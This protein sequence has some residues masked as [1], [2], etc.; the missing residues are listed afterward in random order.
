M[1]FR[2][3]PLN[4]RL[5]RQRVLLHPR[6]RAR[7][8]GGARS[9]LVAAALGVAF[10]ALFGCYLV[11]RLTQWTLDR[12]LYDNPDFAVRDI[13]VYTD[14]VIA[15]EQVRRWAGVQP[16][17]NLL[18]L[19]LAEVKRHLEFIPHIASAS[20]ERVLP[21]TLR[22]RVT[23]RVPVARVHLPRFRPGGGVEPVVYQLDADG[24]V[25]APLAACQRATP[26]FEPEKPL[27]VIT[28]ANPHWFAAGR[29]AEAPPV[30]AAL[31]LVAAFERSPLAGRVELRRI[32]VGAPQ[33]L[34][35]T[36]A[37]GTEVTF[38]GSDYERQLL[39]WAAIQEAGARR[40]RVPASLD[41]AVSNNIP[42]CWFE[43]GASLL[44]PAA[45]GKPSA[46][47]Q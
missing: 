13:V 4:R 33:V 9:R 44:P 45:A 26:P 16:G 18:A 43:A 12:L 10:G 32:D 22:L 40:Q 42:V 7:A 39:R 19:D 37:A 46:S 30:R 29:R 47:R 2:P 27:P 20:V 36:T 8:G 34:V 25:L 31:E 11:W 14:G 1:W 5:S 35:A 21:H 6:L 15:P 3:K 24:F 23:E 28:G 41:L 38:A 17:V